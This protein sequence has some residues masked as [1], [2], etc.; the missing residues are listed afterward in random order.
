MPFTG[1]EL[2]GSTAFGYE[3]RGGVAATH[4]VQRVEETL[5]QESLPFTDSAANSPCSIDG[6][7]WPGDSSINLKQSIGSMLQALESNPEVNEHFC[8]LTCIRSF[9]PLLAH[10]CA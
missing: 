6:R 2:V 4:T 7:S 10:A 8:S 9:P 5:Y 3:L 1:R